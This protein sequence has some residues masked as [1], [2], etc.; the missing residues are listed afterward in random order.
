[1]VGSLV[2]VAL[3]TLTESRFMVVDHQ[4]SISIGLDMKIFMSTKPMRIYYSI[5]ITIGESELNS[6]NYLSK[7]K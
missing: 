5:K 6:V 7:G 4:I 2:A 3:R 1:M